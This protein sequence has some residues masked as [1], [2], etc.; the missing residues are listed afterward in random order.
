MSWYRTALGLLVDAVLVLMRHPQ[1]SPQY[2]PLVGAWSE[3]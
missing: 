1:H 2:L 3:Q